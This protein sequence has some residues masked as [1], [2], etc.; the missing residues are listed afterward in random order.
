MAN[1]IVQIKK[2]FPLGEGVPKGRMR[3]YLLSPRMSSA[4]TSSISQ[5]FAK[6]SID[7]NLSQCKYLLIVEGFTPSCTASSFFEI[8]DITDYRS[9]VKNFM[10]SYEETLELMKGHMDVRYLLHEITY[11]ELCMY[12]D[13]RIERLQREAKEREKERQKMEN[14]TKIKRNKK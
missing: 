9:R 4:E 12:R 5:R 3:L 7:G 13:V 2:A 6:V 14:D 10:R 11:K 8:S 1:K